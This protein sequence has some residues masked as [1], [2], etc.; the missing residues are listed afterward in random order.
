MRLLLQFTLEDDRSKRS[1]LICFNQN[2]SV[3][4]IQVSSQ[5]RQ[6]TNIYH[7]AESTSET[8]RQKQILSSVQCS[9]IIV[10]RSHVMLT[11]TGIIGSQAN[12]ILGFQ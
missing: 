5:G 11:V 4:F 3:Q 6:L 9:V 12:K 1:H 10:M 8:V 7:L 2:D